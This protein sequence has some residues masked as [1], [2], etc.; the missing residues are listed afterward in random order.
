MIFLSA[1][2]I[3]A[4]I[5]N[6][7]VHLVTAQW[8]VRELNKEVTLK[9]CQ[10]ENKQ[11]FNSNQNINL[12]EISAKRKLAKLMIACSDSLEL[13]SQLAKKYHALAAINGSYFKV[14]GKDPD[15]HPELTLF[16]D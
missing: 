6:D 4:Q 8:D 14:R 9:R 13:T 1:S 2:Y 15:D 16:V 3:S 10:I 11:L 12:I 7:S 5:K